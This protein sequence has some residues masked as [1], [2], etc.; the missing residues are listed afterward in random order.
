[1]PIAVRP[2]LGLYEARCGI[3]LHQAVLASIARIGQSGSNASLRINESKAADAKLLPVFDC[4]SKKATMRAIERIFSLLK[5]I[6]RPL[7]DWRREP[8]D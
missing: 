4:F 8:D 3:A 1:M 6:D 7:L 5:R 2:R